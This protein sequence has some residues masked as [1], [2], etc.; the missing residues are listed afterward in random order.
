MVTITSQAAKI[1]P[2]MRQ[3]FL[4]TIKAQIKGERIAVKEMWTQGSGL[5]ITC[6]Y[7]LYGNDSYIK[8]L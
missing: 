2:L 8:I 3:G 4:K 7:K 1:V 6:K 5:Q